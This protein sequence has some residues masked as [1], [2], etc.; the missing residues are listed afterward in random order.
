MQRLVFSSAFQRQLKKTVNKNPI[1]K[2]KIS[3]TLKILL[4]D[5]SQPSLRL[6]KLAGEKNWSIAVTDNIK[7]IIHL[8]KNCIYCLRIGTYDQV[9]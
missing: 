1:L 7:I 5:I 4:K 8:E 6:H 9:Y 2:N 3:K